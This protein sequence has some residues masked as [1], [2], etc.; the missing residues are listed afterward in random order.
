[1]AYGG[2]FDPLS[3]RGGG[4]D[5]TGFRRPAAAHVASDSHAFPELD[6]VRDRLPP[7]VVAAVERRAIETGVGAE[8][9]LIAQGF[10]AEE[11]YLQLLA[12]SLGHTFETF[13]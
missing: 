3:D 10:V 1:M 6:C 11:S 7:A 13:D 4:G 12:R 8:R 5:Q 9:V 2:E